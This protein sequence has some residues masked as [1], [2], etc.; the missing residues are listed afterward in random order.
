MLLAQIEAQQQLVPGCEEECQ[1]RAASI[2]AV[3]RLREELHSALQRPI[4]S[5]EVDWRLWH[6]GEEARHRHPPHHRVL[7]TFY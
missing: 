6:I 4:S 1:I 2:V 3:E 5:I 7:T